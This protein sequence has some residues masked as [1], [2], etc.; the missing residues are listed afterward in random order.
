MTPYFPSGLGVSR[1]FGR[2]SRASSLSSAPIE[3]DRVG[4][5]TEKLQ[6]VLDLLL[7]HLTQE[8]LAATRKGEQSRVAALH[9]EADARVE[10]FDQMVKDLAENLH[11]RRPDRRLQNEKLTPPLRAARPRQL[12]R[13]NRRATGW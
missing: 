6:G 12:M 8:R 2:F 5:V 9:R 11:E 13:P 4:S 3:S 10:Q 7:D 1:P